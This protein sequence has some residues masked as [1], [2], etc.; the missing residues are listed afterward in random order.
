MIETISSEFVK[1][2]YSLSNLLHLN[3]PIRVV[4]LIVDILIV[5]L[6]IYYMYKLIKQTRAEQIAKGILILF[7]FMLIAYLFDMVILKFLLTN[8]MTYGVLLLIVVFQPELRNAFEKIG[9]TSKISKV[10]E[11]EDNIAIRHTITEIVKAIEIMSLKKIGLLIVMERDTKISEVLKDG[12]HLNAKVSSELLQNIF[13]PRTPLH[14]GAVIIDKNEIIAAKCILPLASENTVEKK[15]GTR[16]RAAVGITEISDSIVLIVS[17]ETGIISVAENGKLKRNL[18]GEELKDIL[19][20][21]FD[22]SKPIKAF[23]NIK[24]NKL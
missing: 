7:G 17:E 8:L 23:R 16:H 18:N 13:M 24:K 4:I 21:K 10:F 15:L 11:L 20:K 19:L 14:D 9:R 12:I 22:K 2:M 1:F 5:V 3:S 6:I